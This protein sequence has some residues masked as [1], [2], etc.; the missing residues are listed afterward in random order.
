[1]F[2]EHEETVFKAEFELV[3]VI[4]IENENLN[5][6]HPISFITH[7]TLFKCF[8]PLYNLFM[9]I[10]YKKVCYSL[11]SFAFGQDIAGTRNT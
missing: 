10:M 7:S 2:E 11:L 3:T 5:L 6:F 9:F 4:A 1:M 8:C